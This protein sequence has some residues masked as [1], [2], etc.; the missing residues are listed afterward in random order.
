MPGLHSGLAGRVLAQTSGEDAAEHNLVYL[1][2][3][4][5]GAVE[6]FLH[7]HSAHL[8]G[9]HILQLPPKEPMAV[10]QQLTT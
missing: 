7:D 10:R 5:A 3:L 6:G 4:H 2:G 9:G 8:S 1:L